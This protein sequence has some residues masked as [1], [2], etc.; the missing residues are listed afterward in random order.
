M[1]TVEEFK[2][3]VASSNNVEINLYEE[4]DKI[5]ETLIDTCADQFSIYKKHG[6][7]LKCYAFFYLPDGL[8][9][10]VEKYIFD[11]LKYKILSFLKECYPYLNFKID[12]DGAF[13]MAISETKYSVRILQTRCSW[14]TF[15]ANILK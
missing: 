14:K 7:P 12:I 6:N 11:S 8:N 1:L 15:F 3:K 4:I 9:T 10:S 13:S 2:N 5:Y